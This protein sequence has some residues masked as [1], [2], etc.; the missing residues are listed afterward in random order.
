MA[1]Q[2]QE[3]AIYLRIEATD[4]YIALCLARQILG[5]FNYVYRFR[6][7]NRNQGTNLITYKYKVML[8]D[9]TETTSLKNMLRNYVDDRPL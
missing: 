4:A 2:N 7:D 8:S 5:A 3:G 6:Q 1:L 9:G